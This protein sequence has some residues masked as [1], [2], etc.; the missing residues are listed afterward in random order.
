MSSDA[1]TLRVDSAS[2]PG[3]AQKILDPKSPAPLRQMAAK[4]IAPGLKP[5]EA[6]AV[7]VLLAEGGDAGIADA[8]RATLT[9]LP[10][11]LVAGALTP[12]LDPAVIEALVPH[13][14]KDH[15]VMERLLALPQ[16]PPASVAQAASLA[17]EAVSELIATN[18]ERLLANPTIIEKL[19]M[20]RATRMSTADRILEL[21]VRNKVELPGIPAYAEAAA[22]IM[23]E[24]IPEPS[25]EPTYDDLLFREMDALAAELGE[26]DDDDTHA[27]EEETGEEKVKEKFVPI[28]QKLAEMTVSQKIR[29][30]M[31]GSPSE[32][33]LLVRDRNRLVAT[34]AVKSPMI[35][36]NEVVRIAAS[37]SVNDDVLRVIAQNR[38]WMAKHTIKLTLVM[39]PRTPFVYISRIIPYLMEHELK[40]LSKSKN[41]SGQVA[42]LARQQLLRKK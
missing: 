10:A 4:G 5:H 1:G 2:L 19:Y 34:A 9:K 6:L 25:E 33:A 28:E 18:E 11:P 39:N 14:A 15:G 7:V 21:A 24:L 20:N 16:I 32:R 36:E 42:T 8:A 41:V 22:A 13:Y 3:P 29:R 40:T 26:T 35:Q 27:I 38:E 12:S 30:A 23:N 17:S 31:L 37:R